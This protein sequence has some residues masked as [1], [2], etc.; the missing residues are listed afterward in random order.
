MTIHPIVHIEIPLPNP[1]E[2]SAFYAQ[3]LGNIVDVSRTAFV[4]DGLTYQNH[5]EDG[6]FVGT[7]LGCESRYRH[8]GGANMAMLD[9]HAKWI[10]NNPER[11][12]MQDDNNCFFEKYFASDK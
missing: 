12:T 1:H 5:N 8:R 10:T 11:H 4:G 2:N 6:S 7:L 3:A 9:G